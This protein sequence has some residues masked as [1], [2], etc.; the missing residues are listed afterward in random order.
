MSEVRGHFFDQGR[1]AS[2]HPASFSINIMKRVGVLIEVI[3]KLVEVRGDTAGK[4]VKGAETLRALEI[5][6]NGILNPALHQA[7][8]SSVLEDAE[9]KPSVETPGFRGQ[10]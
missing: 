5:T 8:H 3:E 1:S 10:R 9:P 7:G 2:T 4:T 6:L